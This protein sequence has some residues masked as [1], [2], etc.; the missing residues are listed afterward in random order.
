M[1]ENNQIYLPYQ[2]H[3]RPQ[4]AGR[5]PQLSHKK[6]KTMFLSNMSDWLRLFFPTRKKRLAAY[7]NFLWSMVNS[8][9]IWHRNWEN[10]MHRIPLCI[11]F[12]LV[13]VLVRRNGLTDEPP[14]TFFGI[15]SF[16]SLL[17]CY[18]LKCCEMLIYWLWL[19]SYCMK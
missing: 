3:W 18:D 1:K 15:I 19:S 6:M 17:D 7:S 10:N 5:D 2:F 11:L 13:L 14:G 12:L 8:N 16:A 4:S 9:D